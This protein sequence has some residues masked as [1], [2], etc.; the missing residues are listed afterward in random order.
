MYPCILRCDTCDV[1]ATAANINQFKGNGEYMWHGATCKG[2]LD[3]T[4]VSIGLR[5]LLE[6]S[7]YSSYTTTDIFTQYVTALP[8][9]EQY[10]IM[11]DMIAQNDPHN[12]IL[13]VL[14]Q[15]ARNEQI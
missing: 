5:E 12:P 6:F 7:I 2:Q 10:P 1:V 8:L 15:C 4:S 11:R 3:E 9:A 13:E 14:E